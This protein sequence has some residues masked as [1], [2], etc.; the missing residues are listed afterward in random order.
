MEQFVGTLWH[1]LVTRAADTGHGAAVVRLE[2]IAKPAGILFRALG[3]DRGLVLK[4]AQPTDNAGRRGWLQRLAGSERKIELA[5]RDQQAL[6]LPAAIKLFPQMALN[7][8]LYLWLAMLAAAMRSGEWFIENQ[9]ATQRLLEKFPGLHARYQRLLHASL[10]LRPSPDTLPADEAARERAIRQALAAPGSVA[11]LPMARSPW[12]PVQLWFHP[13][14][15]VA[16][17]AM[18]APAVEQARPEAGQTQPASEDQRRRKAKREDMPDGKDGFMM[19]FRAESMMSWA[20]YIKINRPTEEDAAGDGKRAA[21]DMDALSVARD[22]KNTATRLRFDLDL[23]PEESDDTPLGE[24]ILLPEWH[25]RKGALQEKHCRLQPMVAAHAAPAA[26]PAHLATTARRIR[27]QFEALTPARIWLRKQ[28]DGTEIDLDACVQRMIE[29]KSGTAT[30]D[31]GLYKSYRAQQRDLSCLLLADLSQSTDAYVS[32]QA[33]VI[34]VIRDSLFL[35]SEAL[36]ATGD[37]FGL[38]GFSSL[39]RDNV[40]FH[41]IKEFEDK[42]DDRVRGRIAAVKPGYYTRMGAALRHAS[43]L[44][45][46]QPSQQRLLLLLTDGKPNDLDQYEG[47]YGI[48]DTRQALSAART[49]GIQPFCV[50]VDQKAGSY[51]PH[52]FGRDGYVVIRKPSELPRQLPAL[53][54]QITRQ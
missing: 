31:R 3:G 2:E 25:Y 17:Y 5:W 47:R 6:H 30:A 26:L 43:A 21:D 1:R 40:R 11:F 8:E 38:Y 13:A 4:A 19:F 18:P 54:A 15:P 33:R 12:H 10:L 35:F 51:L 52:L 9:R 36:S 28:H 20:E 46:R 50:T 27:S 24:G 34:D 53:Y 29:R 44:L 23:P 42:Y 22:G 14:P 41:L 7:R 37:R 49:Q 48:E 45:A 32:D 39:R 16:A